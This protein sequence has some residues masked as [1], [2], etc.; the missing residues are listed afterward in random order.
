MK[1]QDYANRENP[2]KTAIWVILL[3][4]VVIATLS[5]ILTVI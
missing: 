4:T 5:T 2:I 1:N 3:L